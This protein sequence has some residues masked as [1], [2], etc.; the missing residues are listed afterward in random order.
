MLQ[1]SKQDISKTNT[2][3]C[4]QYQIKY[5]MKSQQVIQVFLALG[6]PLFIFVI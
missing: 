5:L 4:P 1:A 3:T 2:E 6:L